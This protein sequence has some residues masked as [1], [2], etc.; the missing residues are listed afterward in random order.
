M[1]DMAT[2]GAGKKKKEKC[3]LKPNWIKKYYKSD[4]YLAL[5]QAWASKDLDGDTNK[6]KREEVLSAI[7]KKYE[8][9]QAR[10]NNHTSVIQACLE[11]L[12]CSDANSADPNCQATSNN[13]TKL[14][15]TK[16]DVPEKCAKNTKKQYTYDDSST[17]VI[18]TEGCCNPLYKSGKDDCKKLKSRHLKTRIIPG[19]NSSFMPN[20]ISCA[21]E[22]TPVIRDWVSIAA[23]HHLDPYTENVITDADM[24]ELRQRFKDGNTPNRSA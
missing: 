16:K 8:K 24:V 17:P 7:S 1:Q 20:T 22:N 4:A 18:R 21:S 13:E 5:F 23:S 11:G 6:K 10:R 12:P 14:N 15:V 9:F 2:P 19:T 3:V